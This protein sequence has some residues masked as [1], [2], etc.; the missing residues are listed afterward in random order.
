[1][2][3]GSRA[4][5]A[6]AAVAGLAGWLVVAGPGSPAGA[7]VTF[8]STAHSTDGHDSSTGGT[9]SASA[10][11]AAD[12]TFSES[13]GV[14][15]PV[16]SV[17]TGAALADASAVGHVA[18]TLAPGRYTVTAV[19]DGVT[20]TASSSGSSFAQIQ[21]SATP[22]C[23]VPGC[24]PSLFTATNLV[25]SGGPT[26]QSNAEITVSNTFTITL[27]GVY[28]MDIVIQGTA[29]SGTQ[30]GSVA[31]HGGTASASVSGAVSSVTVTAG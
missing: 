9:W 3:L 21:A 16:S 10:S 5:F 28:T 8:D 25:Y 24:V 12:G 2:R 18:F 13:V 15:D 29:S 20:G 19:L 4:A 7:S 22:Q 26:S 1:M 23:A 31:V 14:D 27:P 6:A 30:T 11:M 17:D